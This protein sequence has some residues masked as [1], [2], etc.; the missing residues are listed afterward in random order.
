[1]KYKSELKTIIELIKKD[2]KLLSYYKDYELF[3]EM[4]EELEIYEK[5]AETIYII[6]HY[7]LVIKFYE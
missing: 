7:L 2:E 6:S 4:L 3:I 1:M 5:E